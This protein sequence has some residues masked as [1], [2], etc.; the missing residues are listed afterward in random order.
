MQPSTLHKPP[1]RLAIEAISIAGLEAVGMGGIEREIGAAVLQHDAGA[2]RHQA[3]AERAVEALDQRGRI[4]LAIDGSD[5]NG[6]AGEAAM[7]RHL[8]PAQRAGGID[9]PA[10][11]P[12][13]VLRDQPFDRH[14]GKGQIGEH[15]VAVAIGDLLRLHHQMQPLLAESR[16]IFGDRHWLSDRCR[17]NFKTH[18][19]APQADRSL[20]R[21]EAAS[22][23]HE[24][25]NHRGERRPK[26]LPVAQSL[27]P[28]THV[29][30]Q[31]PI[32]R[33]PDFGSSISGLPC[34]PNL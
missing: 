15:G 25:G 6:V 34:E 33:P 12:R 10:G 16:E 9:Q 32:G 28:S 29:R 27:T 22:P 2:S 13:I 5:I 21:R 26:H 1:S 30:D 18:A 3:G 23:Y 19:F 14:V 20:A 24:P 31:R 17:G 7:G 8:V 11:L 4:A